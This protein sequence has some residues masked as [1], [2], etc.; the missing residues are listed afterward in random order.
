MKQDAAEQEDHPTGN[1]FEQLAHGLPSNCPLCGAEEIVPI[2]YGYPSPEAQR[3]ADAGKIEL[4]G[5]L[6]FGSPWICESCGHG[7][8]QNRSTVTG[9]NEGEG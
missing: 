6:G 7:R 8:S 1:L 3:L 2:L 9:R 5:C 4:G